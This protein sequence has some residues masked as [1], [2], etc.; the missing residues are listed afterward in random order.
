[1]LHLLAPLLLTCQVFVST[2]ARVPPRV[3]APVCDAP[4]LSY[5]DEPV[6]AVVELG[7]SANALPVAVAVGDVANH[8]ALLL[9]GVLLL[10]HLLTQRWK[11]ITKSINWTYCASP[12]RAGT[13]RCAGSRTRR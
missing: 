5:E 11:H 13:P 4:V 12:S 9:A 3:V 8:A 7:D 6:W 1:M 2:E 10:D